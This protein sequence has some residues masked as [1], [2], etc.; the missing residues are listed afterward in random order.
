MK[1]RH[2][3]ANQTCYDSP[4]YD[5]ILIHHQSMRFDE[6]CHAW[7]WWPFWHMMSKVFLV[8]HPIPQGQTMNALYYK[9][10]MQYQLHSA[11][12]KKCPEQAVNAI[13]QIEN[14]VAHSAPW[15]MYSGFGGGKFCNPSPLSKPQPMS[16]I[17]LPKSSSCCLANDLQRGKPF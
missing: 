11:V 2:R 16:M 8:C 4:L 9:S 5:V 7:S 13:I 10:F 15:R 6:I 3:P 1:C 14:A 17:W 12:R